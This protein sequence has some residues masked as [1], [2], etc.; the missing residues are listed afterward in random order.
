M[1]NP[2][3]KYASISLY[4]HI[5]LIF[6]F[7]QLP[8][9]ILWTILLFLLRIR[10]PARSI[11]RDTS[12]TIIRFIKYRVSLPQRQYI[13]G[14]STNTY[15]KWCKK[16]A[17]PEMIE[18]LIGDAKIMW[19]GPKRT[20]RVVLFFP[21]GG[22]F[23]ALPIF[24]LDFWRY[25]QLK[26]ELEVGFAVLN[27]SLYPEA[28]YPTQLHQACTALDH[29]IS[30]GT[31]PSNIHI[32]GDSAGGNLVLGLLSI[33]LHPLPLTDSSESPPRIINSPLP[34]PLAGVYLMSPWVNFTNTA[35]SLVE[36]TPHD[37]SN[38]PGLGEHVIGC[39]TP[40]S[41]RAYVE[42]LKAPSGWFDGLNGVVD[43]LL[44]HLEGKKT[45]GYEFVLQ[46]GG[47]HD[48]P[49]FDFFFGTPG[50]GEV[51]YSVHS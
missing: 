9:V 20:K 42:P 44:I 6:I 34:A 15:T 10:R 43:R 41:Q 27:Y 5:H 21:G 4:E 23:A 8:L 13:S 33:L 49:Y 22:Y 38:S 12:L 37:I 19:I 32:I 50:E 29:L 1:A 51:V 47:V 18:E 36:N 35:P 40:S 26:L 45:R 17:L 16:H 30:T 31:H 11:R 3:G 39:Y 14:T 24:M 48:D 28:T 25:V 7:L 46:E 2:H